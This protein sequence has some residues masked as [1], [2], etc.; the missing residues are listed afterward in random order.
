MNEK[1]W[2]EELNELLDRIGHYFAR[3]E[4]RQRVRDY[5][6]GLLSPVERKNSWQ[7][8]EEIG[9]ATPYGLQQFLYRSPWDADA[10]RD[11][12]RE[13]VIE[14][15]GDETGI[16][17]V[18]ETGFL[19]KGT[20]SAGVQRQYS[21]TAGRVENSQIGVFLAYVS[22]RGHGLIDRALY[23]PKSWT[24]DRER[25]RKAGIPD[26]VTFQTKP[27]QALTM[28]ERAVGAGV[29]VQ[30]VTADSIY[31]DHRPLRSW[32]ENQPLAYVLGVSGKEAVAIEGYSVRVS[33]IL[34]V[35][36]GGEWVR[37]SAGDGTKGPRDFEWQRIPL[38]DPAVP[39]WQR[40]LLVRRRLDDP[41]RLKTFLCFAP[42]GT[43]LAA[44]VQVAGSRWHIEAC[45]EE[46]KGEVGLDHYEVRSW[47]AWYRHIT[48][49]CLAHA[50]LNVLRS[51]YPETTLLFS[52]KR[53]QVPPSESSLAAFKQKPRPL[54]RLSV[55]EIRRLLWKLVWEWLPSPS[56]SLAWSHWRRHHQAVA[57]NY[58]WLAQNDNQPCA[59]LQL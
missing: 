34:Q 47:M 26:D 27:A 48:L 45:F 25:C 35:R 42:A 49:A 56:F 13:Y 33:E 19:K 7:L 17:I 44:L 22:D 18:D 59:Q 28:L 43:S 39:G 24:E 38:M 31:G 32:L 5:V 2:I 16:L 9:E 40:W 15:L 29:P 20:K 1:Q 30:W 46:A 58:H 53:A 57:M 4:S 6:K 12:V 41:D 54:V 3:S 14:H 51:H 36:L 55:A 37:L 11:E 50:F 23:L 21:G 52:E 10:I 8:A